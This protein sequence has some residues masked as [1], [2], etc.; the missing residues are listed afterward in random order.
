ML[1]SGG[2]SYRSYLPIVEAVNH[3]PRIRV[4][5]LMLNGRYDFLFPA[6]T[7]QEALFALLGSP[8]DQKRHVAYEAGHSFWNERRGQTIRET[9]DWLDR[10]LGPLE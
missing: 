8:P 6:E 9:L 7:S 3:V 5:V 10:Y 4:P 2:F 1:W